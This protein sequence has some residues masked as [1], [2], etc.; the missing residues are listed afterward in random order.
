ML[1]TSV[2]STIATA[3]ILLASSSS[4]EADEIGAAIG[5]VPIFDVQMR[6][7]GW[8]ETLTGRNRGQGDGW[9]RRRVGLDVVA[10][11]DRTVKLLKYASTCIDF[12]LRPYQGLR[13]LAE[14]AGL[15]V[16][17]GSS[18]PV[19][20]GRSARRERGALQN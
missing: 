1:G 7:N 13:R 5:E 15:D 8:G 19:H 4:V 6:C 14:G 18:F 12:E 20:R 16:R 17:N 3:A 2:G 11:H 10:A 9:G